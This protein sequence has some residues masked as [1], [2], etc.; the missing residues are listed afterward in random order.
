[1]IDLTK[2]KF[3]NTKFKSV[4]GFSHF[5]ACPLFRPPNK[6]RKKNKRLDW[7]V[8]L[9]FEHLYKIYVP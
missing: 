2:T 5:F 4:F 8:A 6:K 1:M 9:C 7:I 3:G